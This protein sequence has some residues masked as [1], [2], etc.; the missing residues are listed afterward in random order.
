MTGRHETANQRLTALSQ[1]AWDKLV[2]TVERTRFECVPDAAILLGVELAIEALQCVELDGF[3]RVL[4]CRIAFSL[5]DKFVNGK[6]A[7]TP[8]A[9]LALEFAVFKALDLTLY[10]LTP[11][12]VLEYHA[13]LHAFGPFERALALSMLYAAGTDREY[14]LH[15]PLTL[16]LCIVTI[17]L[18]HKRDLEVALSL[19]AHTGG[20][21]ID[22]LIKQRTKRTREGE[23]IAGAG[24]RGLPG[25]V[26]VMSKISFTVT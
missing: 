17:T 13:T 21:C 15:A 18:V 22:F 24:M 2:N 4:L 19:D 14:A 20:S 26:G 6:R 23:A 12:D 1:L 5:A 25:F 8:A 9:P 7:H 16:G 10:R 3:T 11:Y